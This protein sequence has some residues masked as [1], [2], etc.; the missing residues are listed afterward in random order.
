MSRTVRGVSSLHRDSSPVSPAHTWICA[1]CDERRVLV[2]RCL[3]WTS[4]SGGQASGATRAA[5]ETDTPGRRHPRRA[6][7]S[8]V[9]SDNYGVEFITTPPTVVGNYGDVVEPDNQ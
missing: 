9:L 8:V 5:G 1:A 3:F 2:E 6:A 4:C 7:R